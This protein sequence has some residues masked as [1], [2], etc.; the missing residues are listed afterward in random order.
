MSIQ[1]ARAVPFNE[2]SLAHLERETHHPAWRTPIL[3]SGPSGQGEH[4]R[5]NLRW[6]AALAVT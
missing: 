1:A 2:N 5:L 3:H 6:Q 4:I